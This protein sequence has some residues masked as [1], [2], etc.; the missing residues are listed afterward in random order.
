MRRW[1]AEVAVLPSPPPRLELLGGETGSTHAAAA[2]AAAAASPVGVLWPAMAEADVHTSLQQLNA[3]AVLS[4]RC[5]RG[6][7]GD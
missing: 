1:Q 5:A 6:W 7:P 4:L 2:A 3:S